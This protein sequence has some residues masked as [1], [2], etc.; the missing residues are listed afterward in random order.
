MFLKLGFFLWGCSEKKK[1]R[2]TRKIHPKRTPKIKPVCDSTTKRVGLL[3]KTKLKAE[4][5]SQI[6]K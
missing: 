3:Y 6:G 2:K 5:I 4:E 1:S